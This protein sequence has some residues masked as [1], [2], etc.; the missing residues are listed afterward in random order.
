MNL[1]LYILCMRYILRPHT[2]PVIDK[3]Q[4]F[5]DTKRMRHTF[6]WL[7]PQTCE[8]KF[9]SS[10][11]FYWKRQ[12]LNGSKFYGLNCDLIASAGFGEGNLV[13]Y[14][15]NTKLLRH[16]LRWMELFSSLVSFYIICTLHNAR[17][18]GNFA[19]EDLDVFLQKV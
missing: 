6:F 11:A 8:E 18:I 1:V 12:K 3:S 17:S 10:R 2:R 19:F 14:T 7:M 13:E 9:T 5:Q 4:T 15:L 16:F